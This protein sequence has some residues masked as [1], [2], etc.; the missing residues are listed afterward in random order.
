MF[1]SPTRAHSVGRRPCRHSGCVLMLLTTLAWIGALGEATAA[2]AAGARPEPFNQA[3]PLGAAEPF[4][5]S[6]AIGDVDRDGRPDFAVADRLGQRGE[7]CTYT[8]ELL[9]S[10]APSQTVAFHTVHYALTVRLRDV[11]DDRDLDL[12]VTPALT[13]EVIGV[14]LNDGT[15]HFDEADPHEF[16]LVLPQLCG[17]ASPGHKVTSAGVCVPERPR[18][19]HL[20]A[21]ALVHRPAR[22]SDPTVSPLQAPRPVLQSSVAPRAPPALT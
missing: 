10:R 2:Y 13:Q 16:P 8:I 1:S 5:W 6:T 17:V 22:G 20:L 3:L 12:V 4:G 15:G 18:D 14:W 19:V 9:I 11:D 7:G 21:G